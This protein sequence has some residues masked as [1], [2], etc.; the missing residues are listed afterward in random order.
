MNPRPRGT[1]A[2]SP[3]ARLL[4][5]LLPDLVRFAFWLARDRAV[6]EDV[7]QET[8]IRAWKSREELKDQAAARPWLF[9]IVRREH[10]RLYER[11]RLPTV[12]VDQVEALGDPALASD[13]DAGLD[14]LRRAIMQLPDDYREPLV[15][16]V[17]GGLTTAEIAAELGA[18]PGRG[19]HA[20]VPCTQSAARLLRACARGG[21]GM[22]YECRDAR[23]A[24]G[25]EPHALPPEVSAHLATCA[26]CRQFHQET[27]TLDGHVRAALELP[28]AKF[29]KTASPRHVVSRSPPRWRSPFS[30]GGGFWL[31]SPRS[32]LAS[33]V[34]EHVS[35][36]AGSWGAQEALSAIGA[37]RGVAE[38]GR[39]FRYHDARGVCAAL[40]VP[41]AVS[42]HL[43]VQTANGPM[44]VMLLAHQKIS[45]RQEF[46]EDGY[47]GELLP[48]GE[49]SVAVLMQN[50]KVP[51]AVA[52]QV[53]SGVRW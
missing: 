37:R 11:K 8:L 15:L 13:G 7:V 6:A 21:H 48:A 22:S 45:A 5:M 19:A 1:T 46:S 23:M 16:Q 34:L 29:R 50:G 38:G 47:R 53:V 10:A 36:E 40:R 17:L 41:R 26:A 24:I 44:T 12:D 52:T 43:V 25:G 49:G 20:P 31:W 51:A 35:H 9:T 42:P 32:A 28:L 18:D 33:E 14:D 2:A 39:A 30:L 27:V 4:E 3:F